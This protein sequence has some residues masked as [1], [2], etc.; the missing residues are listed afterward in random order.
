MKLFLS[1]SVCEDFVLFHQHSH[2][3][4]HHLSVQFLP[5]ILSLRIFFALI[6][7]ITSVKSN[8]ADPETGFGRLDPDPHSEFGFGYRSRSAKIEKSRNFVF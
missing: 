4:L 6:L 3:L 1:P 2:Q 8:V 5:K 7:H